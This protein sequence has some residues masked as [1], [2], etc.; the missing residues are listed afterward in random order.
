MEENTTPSEKYTKA[1]NDGYL[2]GKQEPLLAE[3]LTA[4]ASADERMSGLKDGIAEAGKE[5][6]REMTVF[7][8]KSDKELPDK[9]SKEKSREDRERE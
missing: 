1:F 3:K 4:I 9:S 2:L 7:K 6:I 8:T 5:R